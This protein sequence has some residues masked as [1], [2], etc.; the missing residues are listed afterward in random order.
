MGLQAEIALITVM[1]QC[2]DLLFPA[3]VAGAQ[4]TPD[5]PIAVH[6][7]VFRVDMRDA[8]LGQQRVTAGK[9]ILTRDQRIGR[10][11][12]D[13]Q[14]F[15]RDE[16]QNARRFR[17]SPYITCVLILKGNDEIVSGRGLC[18]LGQSAHQRGFA[19]R[20]IHS[21]PVGEDAHD[22][23]AEE[24]SNLEGRHCKARL[25][26]KCVRGSEDILLKP[27]VHRRQ[28]RQHAFEQGRS[29]GDYLH[30]GGI[31]RVFGPIELVLGKIENVFAIHDAK[32]RCR[33][34]DLF[35]Y[36]NGFGERGREFVGDGGYRDFGL[37]GYL[38]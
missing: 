23:R 36:G 37:H 3:D 11:P 26:F 14:I 1:N 38:Y 24:V 6:V 19:G 21:T 7:A 20:W 10:I 22:S 28:I 25:V 30:T 31:E 15:M 9:W 29:D 12:N 34:A 17:S 4:W 13:L 5:R 35:H 32:L 8:L 16:F 27:A 33:H 2:R 18:E